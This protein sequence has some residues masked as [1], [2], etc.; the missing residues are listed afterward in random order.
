VTLLL[1]KGILGT[2]RESAAKL[3]WRRSAP[4][5]VEPVPSPAE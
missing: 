1:P 5:A 2:A 3:K 4:V